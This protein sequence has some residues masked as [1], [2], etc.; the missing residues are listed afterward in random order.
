MNERKFYIPE[1]VRDILS[2]ECH[3]KRDIEAEIRERLRLGGYCEINTPTLEYYDVFSSGDAVSQEMMFK[4]QDKDG[5]LLALRPDMTVPAMR[6]FSGKM[7]DEDLPVKLFY[8]GNVFRYNESGG[9][10]YRE[11]TQAG[12]EVIG[13]SGPSADAEVIAKAIEIMTGLGFDDFQIDL[14]QT[15]FF[16][17]IVSAAGVDEETTEKIRESVNRKDYPQLEM[18]LKGKNYSKELTDKIL[19]LPGLFGEADVLDEAEKYAN[20]RRSKAAVD[21]LRKIIRILEDM[22]M[23]DR[24]TVDLGMLGS[25]NYYTGTIFKGF[26]SG[27]GFPVMSGGRYDDLA[28]KFGRKAGSTGFSIGIDMI[29]RAKEKRDGLSDQEGRIPLTVCYAPKNRE[30]AYSYVRSLNEEGRSAQLDLTGKTKAD[31]EQM[32]DHKGRKYAFIDGSGKVTFYPKEPEK[33]VR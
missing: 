4:F 25:L 23:G 1:G 2:E 27:I 20:N 14:G 3:I 24:I 16:K 13:A 9:G 29:M 26:I 12:I 33:D 22:G 5:S 8:I 7:K 31:L 30:K 19:G 15:E 28:E 18:L 6:V 10:R 17:G 11:F 32:N 21:N